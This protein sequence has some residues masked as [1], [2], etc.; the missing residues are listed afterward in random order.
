MYYY[1]DIT[2]VISAPVPDSPIHVLQDVLP[3][4]LSGAQYVGKVAERLGYEIIHVDLILI[5]K[6]IE[7]KETSVDK[8]IIHDIISVDLKDADVDCPPGLLIVDRILSLTE[9]C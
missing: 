8:D 2:L 9:S 5:L 7:V 4:L 6:D 3:E 1:N